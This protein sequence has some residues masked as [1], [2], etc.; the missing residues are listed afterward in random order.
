MSSWA[1]SQIMLRVRAFMHP[2]TPCTKKLSEWNYIKRSGRCFYC[3]IERRTLNLKS[4][5]LVSVRI[6]LKHLHEPWLGH[7][8]GKILLKCVTSK[9]NTAVIWRRKE[10]KNRQLCSLFF[11]AC[12]Q[13]YLKATIEPRWKRSTTPQWQHE[14]KTRACKQQQ[15][16]MS[17]LLTRKHVLV[18]RDC[19]KG[20]GGHSPVQQRQSIEAF[21]VL[22]EERHRR[23]GGVTDPASQKHTDEL[24]GSERLSGWE[25][26]RRRGS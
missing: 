11:Q 20:G 25:R 23:R 24:G 12:S 14:L 17:V 9:I 4:L 16:I 19:L 2:C 5:W 6:R 15:T 3:F 7:V 13:K 26:A 1:H 21:R 22:G 18:T 8:K 10:K